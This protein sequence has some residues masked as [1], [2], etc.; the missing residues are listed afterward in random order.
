MIDAIDLIFA[1]YLVNSMVE[2]LR[3]GQIGPE[4]LL[5]DHSTLAVLI[6]GLFHGYGHTSTSWR[7]HAK[8]IANELDVITV[9]MDYR[10]SQVLS[11]GPDGIEKARGW[12]VEEGAEQVQQEVEEGIDD[13]QDDEG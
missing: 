11:T 7:E 13:A 4:G 8:R 6:V 3:G 5:D 2:F 9:A 12:Q 1:K 10:G